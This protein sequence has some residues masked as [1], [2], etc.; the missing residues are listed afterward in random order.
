MLNWNQTNI[1]D[2]IKKTVEWYM[3][4]ESSIE[5]LNFKYEYE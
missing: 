5:K 4:Y 1:E 3:E 2:G